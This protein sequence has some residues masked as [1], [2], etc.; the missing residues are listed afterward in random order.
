MS[1]K[2]NQMVSTKNCGGWKLGDI[3]LERVV[4][5]L[6]NS[7]L[8]FL[9]NAFPSGFCPCCLIELLLSSFVGSTKWYPLTVCQSSSCLIYQALAPFI[10]LLKHCLHWPSRTPQP[11]P[12]H[13]PQASLSQPPLLIPPHLFNLYM[14]E[15][16][17]SRSMDLLKQFEK[18]LS[19]L[20]S[21]ENS[22]SLM[23]SNLISM[24]LKR[25]REI[26]SAFQQLL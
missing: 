19:I 15:W 22:F 20:I 21:Q 11:C 18:L 26:W 3:L 25:K 24:P 23:T 12:P 2:G 14:L 8:G 10:S 16:P 5:A 6:P 1:S 17:R 4:Y 7:H 13:T 9:L